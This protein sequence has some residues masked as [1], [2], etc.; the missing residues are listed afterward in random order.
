MVLT[1]DGHDAIERLT[2][3]RRESLT[4]LLEGWDPE[5]HPEVVEMIRNLAHALMADDDRLLADARPSPPSDRAA[6]G[7]APHRA[8]ERSAPTPG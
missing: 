4:E 8:P 7:P 1:P 3:A 5:D 2:V 6:G